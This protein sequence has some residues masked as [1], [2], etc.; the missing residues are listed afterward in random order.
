MGGDAQC[1][2]ELYDGELFDCEL[3]EWAPSYIQKLVSAA[4]LARTLAKET[5]DKPAK[6]KCKGQAS[7]G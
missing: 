4:L 2:D 6:A 3:Y 1:D 7:C 5:K